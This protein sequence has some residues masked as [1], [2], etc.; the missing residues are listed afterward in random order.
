MTN[1]NKILWI[2]YLCYFFVGSVFTTVGVFIPSVGSYFNVDAAQLGYMYTFLNVGVF[3]TIVLSGYL[4][5][6][7]NLKKL[8]SFSCLLIIA[9]A[10][11]LNFEHT[12]TIFSAVM[13][14]MGSVAGIFMSSGSYLVA[15][16]IKNYDQRA[17]K[18]IFADFFF[19]FAGMILPALFGVLLANHINWFTLYNIMAMA[20]V[21]MLVF[22]SSADLSFVKQHQTKKLAK[23]KFDAAIYLAALSSFFFLL[24]EIVLVM[25]IVKYLQAT[26]QLAIASASFFVTL[27]W[28]SKAMGLLI[29][30][31]TV[32]KLGI[33]RYLF[34]SAFIGMLA[35]LLI[36]KATTANE[37]MVGLLILGFV[38]SGIYATLIG[39]GCAQIKNPSPQ[40]VSFIIA[41][42]TFGTLL[43]AWSSGL[44]VKYFGLMG[45]IKYTVLV[46]LCCFVTISILTLGYKSMRKQL[47]LAEEAS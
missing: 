32:L 3:V 23:H 7:F 17:S 45:V 12:V 20:C 16:V 43:T 42:G 44:V 28:F 9:S 37:V 11:L 15:N 39:T 46:Y 6:F 18:L 30:Q 19:S 29:N 13:L 35:M 14:I 24:G 33:Q 5:K 36:L 8:L 47:L 25:W 4:I 21:L 22:L 2:S 1:T 31:F 38:N 26:M 41:V 40:T 27:Y 34:I 10:G